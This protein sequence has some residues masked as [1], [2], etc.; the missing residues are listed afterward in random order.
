[1]PETL[2][3]D[4]SAIKSSAVPTIEHCI[5]QI[6]LAI[7]RVRDVALLTPVTHMTLLGEHYGNN[8]LLK[9]EDMQPVFSFKLRGAYNKI[10]SLS[11]EQMSNGVV[12]ASAGNHAQGVALAARHKNTPASIFMPKTTPSI[13]V[14]A[15][16]RM[17]VEV[18]LEGDTYDEAA[19]YAIEFC[20]RKRK[21]WISPYDDLDVIAGQATVGV[22]IDEQTHTD[23]EAVF[24]PCGGGGLLAGVASWLSKTRPQ[25]RVIGVEASDAA[26]TSAAFKANKR[27]VLPEVGLFADGAAVSQVGRIPFEILRTMKNLEMIQVKTEEICAAIKDIYMD[28]RSIAEPAGAL[29]V[30]GLKKYL[31]AHGIKNKSY[32]AIHSGANLNFDRLRYIAENTELGAHQEALFSVT[33][34]EEPGSF[35]R[36]CSVIG[37]RQVTEFNYRYTGDKSAQIF[38][39]I[40]T[41]EGDRHQ[42]FDTIQKAGYKVTDM[43][44]N[45]IAKRH[46]RYMVGGSVN[47]PDEVIYRMQFPERPGA[48]FN[49]LNILGMSWNITLFH[50]RSHGA[51][52]GRV[53]VGLRVPPSERTQLKKALDSIGFV[54]YAET[55]NVAYKDFLGATR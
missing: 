53:L 35:K 27:V 16:R 25:T 46:V 38:V 13:K 33:I 45:A 1:M 19:S 41:P 15:V 22:E 8:I 37:K 40:A 6:K 3:K 52:Y 28:T 21:M 24:V 7:P 32:L 34:E 47:I 42:L 43:S 18:L 5:E 9:R 2:K 11:S 23:L 54:Y 20:E 50:Y 49:F 44:D 55:D 51:A 31:D 26:C 30:A 48:L 10:A 12:A 36:F 39:G 14:D 29:A 4:S 17:G